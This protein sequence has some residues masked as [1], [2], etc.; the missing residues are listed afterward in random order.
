[1]KS[2]LL[3]GLPCTG[4]SL[5]LLPMLNDAASDMI[6]PLRPIF[7]VAAM[8]AGPAIIGLIEGVAEATASVLRFV[9][10]R[11]FDRGMR[12]QHW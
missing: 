8:G 12:P 2:L 4:I 10:G 9:S 5:S 6:V 11:L 1:M 7:W 3:F